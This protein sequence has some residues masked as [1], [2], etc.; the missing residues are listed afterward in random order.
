MR[1]PR[2]TREAL[3]ATGGLAEAYLRGGVA[4]YVG[5]YWPVGDTAAMAFA[6]AFYSAIV[7]GE[8][9]GPAVNQAR[10]AVRAT[11]SVDWADY[12]H[13]GNFDFALKRPRA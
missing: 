7:R 1:T 6:T 13:Y 9:V 8:R 2:T 3:A 5:T 10:A 12:M 4:N 11:G